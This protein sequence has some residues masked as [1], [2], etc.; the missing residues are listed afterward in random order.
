MASVCPTVSED[1]AA[2]E[3]SGASEG[4]ASGLAAL[5]DTLRN[6][7]IKYLAGDLSLIPEIE[8]RRAA[9]RALPP[10]HFAGAFQEGV[11]SGAFASAPA[12][13]SPGT[14]EVNICG[15]FLGGD[16]TL[17]QEVQARHAAL[18]DLPT[19]ARAGPAARM[20]VTP[21]A[22]CWVPAGSSAMAAVDPLHAVQAL[23]EQ[24][25]A[26]DLKRRREQL[27]LLREETVALKKRL[28]I[29]RENVALERERL[30]IDKERVSVER[31]RAQLKVAYSVTA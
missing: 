13:A 30:R 17:V 6:V 24:G 21:T 7:Y 29:D 12:S 31:E 25:A 1:E 8:Q 11:A 10:G 19:T 15:R 14:A 4:S 26:C 9:L 22:A 28:T 2:S 16:M 23:G 3:A 20:E 18:R 27:D 5:Q